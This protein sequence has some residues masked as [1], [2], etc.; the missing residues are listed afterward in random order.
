MKKMLV[1]CCL[2]LMC[3]CGNTSGSG[4]ISGSEEKDIQV[5]VDSG[6]G[7][8]E[9]P[10][11]EL[12]EE[13]PE[14]Y[15]LDI[16]SSD[17]PV[18]TTEYTVE[19]YCHGCYIVSKNDGMLYGVLDKTGGELVPVKYDSIYFLNEE[20]VKEGRDT[21]LYIQA[22][23]EDEYAVFTHTGSQILDKE[24]KYTEYKLGTI[25]EDSYCFMHDD[26]EDSIMY[27][28][29]KNGEI[30]T[31]IDYS[32]IWNQY[33]DTETSEPY[34]GGLLWVSENNYGITIFDISYNNSGDS[35]FLL[36][37]K[38]HQV[39]RSWPWFSDMY[40]IIDDVLM[41]HEVE[42]REVIEYKTYSIDRDGN[43]QDLGPFQE[44]EASK[45]KIAPRGGLSFKTDY[46]YKGQVRFENENAK[47]YSSNDT[48]KLEDAEGNPLYD[49]RY[50][51]CALA[52]D[53]YFLMNE[54]NQICL[55]DN[56][57]KML[58]DYGYLTCDNDNIYFMGAAITDQNHFVGDDGVSFVLGSDVY[59]F[60]AE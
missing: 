40:D 48:W 5:S 1:L 37:D 25:T 34:L 4:N 19:E 39:I 55:I 20:A 57:G 21:V 49:E 51:K 26:K 18:F 9:V 11:L 7:N 30:V 52:D 33:C 41:L 59:F 45:Y 42:N 44:N 53:G 2:V 29:K 23:Y 24:V 35:C 32:E 15:I 58:L 13:I 10:V 50:Y 16:M 12:E 28:Y 46:V 27:L 8:I 47:L 3:G 54:D 56:A 36:F 22:V 60:S 43:F 31:S 6:N 17:Q 14:E 38:N